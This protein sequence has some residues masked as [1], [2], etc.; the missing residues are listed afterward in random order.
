MKINKFLLATMMAVAFTACKN[1]KKTDEKTGVETTENQASDDKKEKISPLSD[2]KVGN[3]SIGQK[4]PGATKRYSMETVTET[5]A[6]EGGKVTETYYILYADPG[7]SG[8]KHLI[9]KYGHDSEGETDK[10][11]EILVF[12]EEYQTGEGIGVGS[13]IGEFMETYPDYEI[14]YTYV[15]D[16]YVIQNSKS[17][18]QF[19]L[20]ESGFTGEKQ[21]QSEMTPL[22]ASD[23]KENTRIE[24]IRVYK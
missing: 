23:F 3:F 7:E 12:D 16:R 22:K 18:I 14:W 6:V 4:M 10:I 11:G 21:I 2:G 5:R 24:K 1:D 9:L 8:E 15:S 19:L 17:S 13:T 20:D